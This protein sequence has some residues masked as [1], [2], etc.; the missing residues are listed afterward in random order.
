MPLE[1][2]KTAP[3]TQQVSRLYTLEVQTR[4]RVEFQDVTHLIQRLIEEAGV[5]NGTCHLFVP[6]TTAAV[7]I[8]ENDDPALQR[9]LDEFL[10]RLI[11]YDGHYHHNDGNCDAHL[12]AGVVG[13]SKSMLFEN[14]RL[15]LG[16][17]QGVFFCEFDGPR[18]RRLCVKIVPD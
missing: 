6:H 18:R 13:C 2:G 15:I 1:R 9:D 11:P 8:N 12:K 3:S 17:W 10:K 4:S 14:G 16:T 5:Q 7:L